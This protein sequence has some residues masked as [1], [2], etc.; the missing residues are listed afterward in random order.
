MCELPEYQRLA[1]EDKSERT[2]MPSQAG[3]SAV[4]AGAPAD[5]TGSIV[6]FQFEPRWPV[7]GKRETAVGIMAQSK[8][9]STALY[10]FSYA[11]ASTVCGPC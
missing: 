10:S 9:V 3:S 6:E 5:R 7:K 11:R 4:V 1:L 2:V 8:E